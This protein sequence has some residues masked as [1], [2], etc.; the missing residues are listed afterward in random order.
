MGRKALHVLYQE[1]AD[2]EAQTSI[3]TKYHVVFSTEIGRVVLADILKHLGVMEDLDPRD[4]V[5][6]A[7][8]NYAETALYRR[9]GRINYTAALDLL[10]EGDP[11]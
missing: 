8:R 1:V 6:N 4:P 2:K 3:T 11:Y 10:M 7:L 5:S 9:V